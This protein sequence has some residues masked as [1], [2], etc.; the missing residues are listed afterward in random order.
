MCLG[1]QSGHY[2]AIGLARGCTCMHHRACLTCIKHCKHNSIA[3]GRLISYF[4]CSHDQMHMLKSNI[5]TGLMQTNLKLYLLVLTQE[6][7]WAVECL[8][9]HLEQANGCCCHVLTTMMTATTMITTITNA[10]AAA[11]HIHRRD[12][13]WYV[14]ACINSFTPV[15]TDNL[16][17]LTCTILHPA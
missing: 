7:Q 15:S 1:L 14:L 16:D 3:A 4:A 11:Q 9:P 13:F 12:L 5:D 2:K 6:S 17:L 8:I 10:K